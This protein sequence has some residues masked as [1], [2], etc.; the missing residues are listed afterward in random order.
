MRE[1]SHGVRVEPPLYWKLGAQEI[2][3]LPKS[4]IKGDETRANGFSANR[5]WQQ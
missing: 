2:T 4:A 3:N 5:F 1:I